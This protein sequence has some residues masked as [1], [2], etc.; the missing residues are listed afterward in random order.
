MAKTSEELEQVPVLNLLCAHVSID[1][2]AAAGP[3]F[4]DT[5]SFPRP[6]KMPLFEPDKR[7]QLP[8]P[9]PRWQPTFL[10]QTRLVKA[11]SVQCA[12]REKI[13]EHDRIRSGSHRSCKTCSSLCGNF[14]RAVADSSSSDRNLGQNF[15]MMHALNEITSDA[16]WISDESPSEKKI[17]AD[18]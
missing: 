13:T 2:S 8:S 9:W 15:M 16:N 12:N 1:E 6:L 7:S 11:L 10:L 5:S 14:K 17:K 3:P 18:D 4:T